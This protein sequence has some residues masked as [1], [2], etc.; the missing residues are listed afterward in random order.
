LNRYGEAVRLTWEDLPNHNAGV[1]LDAYEIMPDH[2]HGIIMI[3]NPSEEAQE[4]SLPEAVRQFKTFSAKRVNKLRNTKGVPVWQRNYHEHILRI[5]ELGIFR[6]YIQA[7]PANKETY[8]NEI[9]E[10][11]PWL[12]EMYDFDSGE[13]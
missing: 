9:L 5:D 10:K 11:N 8:W 4:S 13:R 6:K 3:S 12:K 2:F 7:N 1:I